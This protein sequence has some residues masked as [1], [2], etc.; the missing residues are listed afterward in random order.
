[1]AQSLDYLY[2]SR[3]LVVDESIGSPRD[4]TSLI[5]KTSRVLVV[6][7]KDQPKI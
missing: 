3:V 1:M 5:P 6:N 7:E 4:L 2:K